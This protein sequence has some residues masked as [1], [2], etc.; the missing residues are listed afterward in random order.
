MTSVSASFND[1]PPHFTHTRHLLQA[2]RGNISRDFAKEELYLEGQYIHYHCSRWFFN[3]FF[4]MWTIGVDGFSIFF[5]SCEPLVSM[6]SHWFFFFLHM[7]H[8]CQ[9]FF[10]GFSDFNH[11]YQW[12]FQCFFYKWTIAIEW[13]VCG[14]PLTSMVYQWF[15]WKWTAVHKKRP[16]RKKKHDLLKKTQG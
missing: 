16:K 3:G 2:S 9:W 7:N 8:W 5:F 12:F 13:M 6:A 1:F 4:Y 15:W 10:N 14:S 11:W